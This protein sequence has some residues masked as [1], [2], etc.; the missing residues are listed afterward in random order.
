[1][2]SRED[3]DEMRQIVEIVAKWD[4]EGYSHCPF[5]D[6]ETDYDADP[7]VFRHT[8]DCLVVLSRLLLEKQERE[9]CK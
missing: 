2:M 9:Q 8:P 4:D 7:I 3:F 5:C 1:M 6:G